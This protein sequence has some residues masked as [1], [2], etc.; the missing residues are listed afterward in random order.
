[1]KNLVKWIKRKILEKG[2][3]QTLLERCP[4]YAQQYPYRWIDLDEYYQSMNG[5]NSIGGTPYELWEKMPKKCFI[6]LA[7]SSVIKTE[8]RVISMELKN[9]KNFEPRP[10]LHKIRPHLIFSLESL[11]FITPQGFN[12]SVELI[13]LLRLFAQIYPTVL[14]L[15][16]RNKI[17][18]STSNLFE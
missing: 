6:C 1:L 8:S 13:I 17:G 18:I 7:L 10:R 9:I 15:S 11:P 12:R 16:V 2:E 4:G 3:A 14:I 5:L